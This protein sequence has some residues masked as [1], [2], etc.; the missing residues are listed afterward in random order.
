M[1]LGSKKVWKSIIPLCS[2]GKSATRF[3]L[4]PKP[5]S[6]S[7]GPGDTPVYLNVYDLTP[8]NG[9]AYWAGLGIFHSGVEVH[10]VEYAF[11]AHDYPTS[12]VFEVEPRQCPG[13][14]FRRSIFIGTTCLDSI[15]ADRETNSKVGK[16]TGKNSL[17]HGKPRMHAPCL[18][19]A[20][21]PLK[22]LASITSVRDSPYCK[23]HKKMMRRLSSPR[24]E[25]FLWHQFFWGRG[26]M[27]LG[28]SGMTLLPGTA[29]PGKTSTLG[30]W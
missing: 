7:Y 1:K 27:V 18:C 13:F 28:V 22:P 29:F 30:K 21:R 4:F 6:A 15:Q 20:I 23:C 2:K 26:S 5:R 3:C 24:V 25:Q 19:H 8:M 17:Y 16:S 9:Y 12:G 14:K 10:G 11:G